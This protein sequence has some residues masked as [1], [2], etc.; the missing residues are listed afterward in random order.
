MKENERVRPAILR[1]VLRRE[2]ICGTDHRS[3]NSALHYYNVLVNR[4]QV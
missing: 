1:F 3:F 2:P 4:H